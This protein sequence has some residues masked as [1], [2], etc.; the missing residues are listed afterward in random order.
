MEISHTRLADGQRRHE[1]ISVVEKTRCWKYVW[2]RRVP[3]LESK[4]CLM[5][6]PCYPK[7]YTGRWVCMMAVSNAIPSHRDRSSSTFFPQITAAEDL[8]NSVS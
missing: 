2:G 4:G 7:K 3:K 6:R 8:G 5:P 1:A